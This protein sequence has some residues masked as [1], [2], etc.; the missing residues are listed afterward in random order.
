M[1]KTHDDKNRDESEEIIISPLILES[2]KVRTKIKEIISPVLIPVDVE[3]P[4]YIKKKQVEFVNEQKS[5]VEFVTG[6][7]PQTEFIT[8]EQEQ[9]KYITKEEPTIKYVPKEETIVRYVPK[10]EPTIKYVKKEVS[11][12]FPVVSMEQ[13]N[14]LA[15]E[16]TDMLTEAK[17]MI[18]GLNEAR[19]SLVEA[20]AEVKEAIPKEIVVPNI[21]YEDV[22]HANIIKETVHVIGKIVA[23]GQ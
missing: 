7:K 20:I 10:D 4:E 21:I 14:K 9:I 6:Q 13:V 12:E 16:L 8:T 3:V 18:G 23:R 5:Q 2:V 11:Y 17:A 19:E 22:T 1:A 15:T